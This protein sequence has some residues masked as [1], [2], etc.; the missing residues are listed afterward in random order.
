MSR[1]TARPKRAFGRARPRRTPRPK[2]TPM[3]R[4]PTQAAEQS[5]PESDI[6]RRRDDFIA[7]GTEGLRSHPRD[8]AEQHEAERGNPLLRTPRS[9]TASASGS[10]APARKNRS[11]AE[12]DKCAAFAR[13]AAQAV[14]ACG[15]RTSHLWRTLAPASA[16]SSTTTTPGGSIRR[17]TT[18]HQNYSTPS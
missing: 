5:P 2:A 7:E 8:L 10:C 15:S 6:Q 1:A 13:R 14:N 12:I 17:S 18:A 16:T 11:G 9:R 4:P 3:T